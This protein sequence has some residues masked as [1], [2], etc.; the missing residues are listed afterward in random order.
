MSREFLFRFVG[1]RSEGGKQWNLVERVQKS[2][3][4][5]RFDPAV[6]CLCAP[7][8]VFGC[9]GLKRRGRASLGGTRKTYL[10]IFLLWRTRCSAVDVVQPPD[11]ADAAGGF[12]L[13]QKKQIVG[14]PAEVPHFSLTAAAL[15]RATTLDSCHCLHPSF[16]PPP[17]SKTPRI[18]L[19]R[20]RSA[21]FRIRK[22]RFPRTK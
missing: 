11:Y 6:L 18:A 13:V 3:D 2:D 22:K 17:R 5:K 21:E 16:P 12:L 14:P 8:W 7:M 19:V 9:F 10:F 1:S 4:A 15:V 20:T